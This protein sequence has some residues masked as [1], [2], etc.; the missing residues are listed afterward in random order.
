MHEARIGFGL[1]ALMGASAAMA[2]GGAEWLGQAP[3]PGLVIGFQRA[4]AR[5]MIIERVPPGETVEQWSRMVT[6]QRFTGVIARGGTLDEWRGHFLD[7]LRTGCPGFRGGDATHLTVAGRPA[8]DLR[9][10]C[11]VNPATGRPET[12]LL[13]AIAGRADLHIAQI[14]FRHV[15]SEAEVQWASTQLAGVTLCTP[16]DLVPACRGGPEAVD[17]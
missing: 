14:A 1:L 13:R 12:F 10:D 15:P 4:E 17:R 3:L 8:L 9:I 5:G 2:Q 7:G 16:E 11:P 6:V